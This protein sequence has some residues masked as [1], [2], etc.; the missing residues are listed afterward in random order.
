MC[1]IDEPATKSP[2]GVWCG[3]CGCEI[4]E[5]DEPNIIIGKDPAQYCSKCV[6]CGSFINR[7]GD[8]WEVRPIIKD[9]EDIN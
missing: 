5:D 3:G 2:P 8:K 9:V 4:P 1:T 7:R 6:L